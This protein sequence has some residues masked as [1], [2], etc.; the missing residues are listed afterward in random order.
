MEIK[1]VIYFLFKKRLN[2]NK[3]FECGK[4]SRRVSF[5]VYARIHKKE[6]PY[7]HDIYVYNNGFVHHNKTSCASLLSCRKRPCNYRI[8][9]REFIKAQIWQNTGGA[10]QLKN[11]IFVNCI[12]NDSGIVEIC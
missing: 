5:C 9:D 11:R 4:R 8:R 1:K 3:Y 12:I 2:C 6:G 7:R 10:T